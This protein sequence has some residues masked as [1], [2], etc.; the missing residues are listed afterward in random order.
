MTSL[1]FRSEFIARAAKA[2][3]KKSYWVSLIAH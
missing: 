1:Y 2:V 3:S